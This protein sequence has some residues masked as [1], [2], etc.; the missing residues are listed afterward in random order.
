VMNMT[1]TQNVMTGSTTTSP[2][3]TPTTTTTEGTEQ[4]RPYSILTREKAAVTKSILEN[5]YGNGKL[6]A[7]QQRQQATNT[8]TSRYKEMM[9]DR[10]SAK[11][12]ERI[13]V[14]GRGAF[15]EVRLVRENKTG[16]VMAMKMLKKAEMLKKNQVCPYSVEMMDDV[17]GISS[18]TE[19]FFYSIH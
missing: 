10:R 11:D 15:G 16:Q 8:S 9:Q 1:T 12:F 6:L 13:K 3:T 4:Q 2:P 17:N 19:S 5:K 18:P 14:I 7:Q